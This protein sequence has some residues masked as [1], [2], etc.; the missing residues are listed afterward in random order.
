MVRSEAYAG[1]P[2][3]A[4]ERMYVS[5]GESLPP[6]RVGDAREIAEAALL[7]AMNGFLMGQV[8]DVDGEHMIWQY[9]T[10]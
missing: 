5:T 6:G 7:A 3:E 10:R 1:M 8:L 2:N 4:R 9:A